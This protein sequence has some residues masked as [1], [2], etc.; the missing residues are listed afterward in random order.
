M[1][2]NSARRVMLS[3]QYH[4]PDRCTLLQQIPIAIICLL[5]LD[6]GQS[7][8]VCGIAMIGFWLGTAAIWTRR[9]HNPLAT[10]ICFIRWGF[11]P[12]FAVAVALAVIKVSI[13]Q[14][15]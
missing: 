9:P 10:D 1:V 13:V 4:P 11:L 8:R 12:L 2:S 5:M 14:A 6:F 7:A 3:A 15:A